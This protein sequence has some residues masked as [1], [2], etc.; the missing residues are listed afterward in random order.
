MTVTPIHP[1]CLV[2][3][4]ARTKCKSLR[5]CVVFTSRQVNQLRAQLAALKA[6]L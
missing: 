1:N 6:A 2:C 3:G 4:R 5:A